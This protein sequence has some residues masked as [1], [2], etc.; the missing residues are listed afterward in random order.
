MYPL[1]RFLATA[2]PPKLPSSAAIL[3]RSFFVV[4][5]FMVFW[6]SPAFWIGEIWFVSPLSVTLSSTREHTEF[7]AEAY[8]LFYSSIALSHI[9][10]FFR[11]ATP[12]TQKAGDHL[13][14]V[15]QAVGTYKRDLWIIRMV[16]LMYRCLLADTLL[17]LLALLLSRTLSDHN[18]LREVILFQSM[19]RCQR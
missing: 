8:F 11:G 4:F 5:A 3:L 9:G 6:L 13:L 16:S 14:I 7:F 15:Y 17:A 18:F 19:F 2:L 12:A 10:S 1:P